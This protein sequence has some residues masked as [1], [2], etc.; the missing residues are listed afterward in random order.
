MRTF[1][2]VPVLFLLVLA[3][4][5]VA[6]ESDG[7]DVGILL[8]EVD[9]WNEGISIHNYGT[10]T[11]DLSNYTIA[12]S[13]TEGNEGTISF[14]EELLIGPGQT[15]TFL[16]NGQDDG[17]FGYRHITFLDG[18]SG[19]TFSKQ[20]VLNNTDEGVYLFKGDQG[21]GDVVDVFYYGSPKDVDSSLWSGD[22][23]GIQKGCFAL[24]KDTS[25]G[26]ADAWINSKSGWSNLFF[27]PN[28]KFDAY[29]EPFVFPDS[30]G[31]PIFETLS[32]A[33][34]SVYLNMYILS[35]PNVYGLLYDLASSGVSVNILLERSP[36]DAGDPLDYS[37]F[38][39]AISDKG[40]D[41]RF[42]GASDDRYSYD[43][44]KY[45]IIDMEKVIITS[46]NWTNSNLS[47]KKIIPP[48]TEDVNR[49]WGAIVESREYASFMLEVFESD[50]SLVYGDVHTFSE[51][52]PNA[53]SKIPYYESPKESFPMDRYRVSITPA[54][55]PDSSLDA[56][57]YYMSLS[58]SRIYS[59][60]QSLSSS[61]LNPY[62]KPVSIM[63]E[64]SAKGLDC[65]LILGSNNSSSIITGLNNS[66]K[67][68]TSMMVSPYLHNK[69]IVCDDVTLIGS[70]NWTP[71]SFNNNREVMLA[72]H[73]KDVSNYYAQFFLSDFDRTYVYDGLYV[74]F[75]EIED[76]Y[77]KVDE[78]TVSVSVKQDGIT[79]YRWDLDGVI[80]DTKN[81]RTVLRVSEGTHSLKVTVSDN[82][83]N[84][85]TVQKTFAVGDPDS[86][87]S[88]FFDE[89]KQYLAPLAIIII[90]L[91]LAV[92]RRMVR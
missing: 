38:L 8:Y 23:F 1:L 39:K 9:P 17:G 58:K 53:K 12:D 73:S 68:K 10:S 37:G 92:V 45:C 88:S 34:E 41:V 14:S 43:H 78:I 61:L 81:P 28:L 6:E 77:D 75:T 24:R 72:I 54:L 65:R 35:S 11:L 51:L 70:V 25:V 3:P 90:A 59:E 66:T 62:Q 55:S 16:N 15:Y 91:L 31:I 82:K 48:T 44:A 89:Y 22:T 2:A 7:A 85:G 40:A 5:I 21:N 36:L 60:Q 80:K 50:S 29:V 18:E 87:G 79:S 26:T 67:V 13:F 57:S 46:E 84:E 63:V 33:N 56:T 27:D 49:G 19:V 74:S 64:K 47:M 83:G 30:G 4:F 69:G 32:Q 52:A 76:S 86:D 20:F 71:N 42:I